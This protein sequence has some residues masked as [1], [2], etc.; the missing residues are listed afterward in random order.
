MNNPNT[1]E[2]ALAPPSPL[3]CLE[4][5]PKDPNLLVGG[6]YNGLVS[7]F[8]TRTGDG[9]KE[10]SIIEKSHRDVSARKPSRH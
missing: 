8:D 1:P 9:P 2:T 5:N 7:A 4:Y 10:T 6:S 3:C